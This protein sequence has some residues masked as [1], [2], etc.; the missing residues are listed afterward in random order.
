MMGRGGR[1]SRGF[2]ITA[3]LGILLGCAARED[4]EGG[5]EEDGKR[6][7]SGSDGDG[8]HGIAGHAMLLVGSGVEAF[9]QV[10]RR[11]RDVAT[12][13]LLVSAML[14][15]V[16]VMMA[17]HRCVCTRM[18]LAATRIGLRDVAYTIPLCAHAKMARAVGGVD[19]DGSLVSRTRCR[20]G[21]LI[22][23]DFGRV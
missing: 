11:E 10:G 2:E 21:G 6:K 19:S 18:A 7:G 17:R 23:F 5:G 22:D 14:T 15:S 1:G 8:C 13:D 20:H 16:V 12:G 3:R 9:G 4:D